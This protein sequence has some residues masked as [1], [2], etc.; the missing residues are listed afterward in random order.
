MSIIKY[1]VSRAYR[2]KVSTEYTKDL[3]CKIALEQKQLENAF[4]RN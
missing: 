1:I 2:I 4:G 3:C